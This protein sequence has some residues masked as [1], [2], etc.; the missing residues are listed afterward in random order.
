MLRK[1]FRDWSTKSNLR[2]EDLR[3]PNLT[4]RVYSSLLYVPWGPMTLYSTSYVGLWHSTRHSTRACDTLIYFLWGSLSFYSTIYEG[5]QH[6]TLCSMRANN[7]LLFYILWRPATP[8]SMFHESLG[9]PKGWWEIKQTAQKMVEFPYERRKL[10][11]LL[12]GL[13]QSL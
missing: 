7:A 5:L 3:C 12:E 6:S 8:Y 9:H 1:I 2:S 10:H 11:Y 4:T 13:L